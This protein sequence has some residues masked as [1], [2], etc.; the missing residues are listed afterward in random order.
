MHGN[1]LIDG[2]NIY[3]PNE[4]REHGFYYDRI[5]KKV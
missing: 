2:R 3:D 5:G 4:M 1:V